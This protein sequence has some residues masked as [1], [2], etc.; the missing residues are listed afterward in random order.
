[1]SKELRR[2]LRAKVTFKAILGAN[3]RLIKLGHRWDTRGH[4]KSFTYYRIPSPLFKKTERVY[5][6][7]EE[8]H[9]RIYY[10]FMI[11]V[12]KNTTI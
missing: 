10:E 7:I 4:L 5:S 12:I 1:V 9:S 6:K 11:S 2:D 8:T 3:N